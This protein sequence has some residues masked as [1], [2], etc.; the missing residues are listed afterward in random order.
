MRYITI[1]CG[2]LMLAG[3]ATKQIRCE[4]ADGRVTYMGRYDQ[5]TAA[6]FI[7]EPDPWVRDF[8][9]KASCRKV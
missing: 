8:Y 3:C 9:S 6:T 1:A 7:H 5:E 2:L 4:A